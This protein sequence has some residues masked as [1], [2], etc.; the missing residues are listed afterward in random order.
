MSEKTAEQVQT[1]EVT[2]APQTPTTQVETKPSAEVK[3]TEVKV[4]SKD[5]KANAAFIAQRHKI[6][7][8][9]RK[10]AQTNAAPVPPAPAPVTEAPVAVTP[11]PQVQTT[12][13]APIY[14]ELDGEIEKQAITDLSKDVDLAKIP[15]GVIDVLDLI[16]TNP[17]LTKLYNF[18]P[19]L[20]I[21]EA[22]DMYLSKS[23]ISAPPPVPVSSTP[24]G[25]MGAEKKNDLEALV[26]HAESLKPGTQ[27]WYKAIAKVNAELKHY[28]M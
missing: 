26:A 20:A 2:P 1:T 12:A 28:N 22:K 11:A 17:R 13:P 24:S 25:G 6:K 21:R 14:A 18:D 10:L 9:E 7:E 16:D 15:G 19:K 4:E 3:P 27:E 5:S 8:L 23:G